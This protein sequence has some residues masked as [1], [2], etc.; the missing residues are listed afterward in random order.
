MTPQA[1]TYRLLE[2]SGLPIQHAGRP[3]RLLPGEPAR[4]PVEADDGVRE[5]A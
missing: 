5:A 1:T 2:G 4:L 3:L